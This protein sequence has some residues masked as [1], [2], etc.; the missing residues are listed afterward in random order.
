MVAKKKKKEKFINDDPE[1]EPLPF[2]TPPLSRSLFSLAVF[3]RQKLCIREIFF[4]DSPP[5]NS[6]L[7]DRSFRDLE[8][9]CTDR[10]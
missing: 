5:S 9:N 2:S 1:I 4:T 6:I 3:Y 7:R 8:G 10:S